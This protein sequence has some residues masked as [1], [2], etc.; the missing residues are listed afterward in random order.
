[1]CAHI[2]LNYL[3]NFF[4]PF[5]N[6]FIMYLQSFIVVSFETKIIPFAG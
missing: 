2:T 1:M 4:R 6:I 5:L 3:K